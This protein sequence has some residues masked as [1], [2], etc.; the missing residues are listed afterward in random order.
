MQKQKTN[1][2][3]KTSSLYRSGD[4]P[5]P[6]QGSGSVLGDDSR[7]IS[8]QRINIPLSIPQNNAFQYLLVDCGGHWFCC[9][10][11]VR[12]VSLLCS[13]IYF[14]MMT[15]S[16]IYFTL[17]INP[18][19]CV[20]GSFHLASI[21][22]PSYHRCTSPQESSCFLLGGLLGYEALL[23]W[24]L[25]HRGVGGSKDFAYT[26]LTLKRGI[27]SVREEVGLFH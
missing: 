20:T 2:K 8:G 24:R 4:A 23:T 16:P 5:A 22:L 25:L 21:V 9:I 1:D 17:G 26:L 11:F 18:K 6:K 12:T 13:F 15:F 14:T 10:M 7:V 27:E 19:P 3:W